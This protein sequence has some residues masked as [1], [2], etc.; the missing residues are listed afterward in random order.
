MKKQLLAVLLVLALVL[1]LSAV[2]AEDSVSFPAAVTGYVEQEAGMTG[3]EWKDDGL[4]RATLAMFLYGDLTEAGYPEADISILPC[5]LGCLDNIYLLVF[6]GDGANA[7]KM[8][9]VVYCPGVEEASYSVSAEELP[10]T[11]TP[12]VFD[13]LGVSEYWEIGAEDMMNVLGML[14]AE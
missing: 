9:T 1:N 6:S 4:L 12:Q 13:Q 8:I 5:Y 3:S 14:T 2:L 7:G 10:I 11:F